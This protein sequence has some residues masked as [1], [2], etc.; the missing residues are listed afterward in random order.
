MNDFL[1]MKIWMKPDSCDFVSDDG[2]SGGLL[3][4]S[5]HSMPFPLTC[6]VTADR[7]TMDL[8][9]EWDKVPS[10]FSDMAVKFYTPENSF[11]YVQIKAS[12]AK[13]LQGHNVYGS[14]DIEL[15]AKHMLGL[16]RSAYPHFFA[17]LDLESTEVRRFD[18]TNSARFSVPQ[19]QQLQVIA[20]LKKLNNKKVLGYAGPFPE[21]VYFY[22]P[23]ANAKG[24]KL[25]EYIRRKC[26][27]KLAEL[28]HY[29]QK[30]DDAARK[31]RFI[32]QK[33]HYRLRQLADINL[34]KDLQAFAAGLFR[35]EVS[36]YPRWLAK[37]ENPNYNPKII[38]PS[39]VIH[40]DHSKQ[41]LDHKLTTLIKAQRTDPD[42][43]KKLWQ[44]AFKPITEAV[45]G[46]D[47]TMNTDDKI[48][49]A[50]KAKFST[51]DSKGRTRYTAANN[52]YKFYKSIKQEGYEHV[53]N[54]AHNKDVD[55]AYSSSSF[56]RYI[57]MFKK[58]GLTKNYLQNIE[59]EI[60]ATNVI[61]MIRFIDIDF[62]QQHPAGW[63][64]PVSE[65]AEGIYLSSDVKPALYAV[66]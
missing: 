49:T 16:L 17:K 63:R 42:I 48:H 46:G 10:S 50:L 57:G 7:T 20:N 62:S 36:V 45:D 8:N 38:L 9:C 59:S 35:W 43:F 25:S 39:G 53:F 2:L 37:Q 40:P 30:L 26:Y 12:P 47:M 33:E 1:D 55:G 19:N 34:D 18:L 24:S 32:D 41:F 27:L 60:Q 65:Y 61:P 6:R 44:K 15:C 58:I 64:E 22:D 23:Y 52:A 54:E 51:V 66:N 29:A 11:P 5:V 14:D 4:Q 21:T 13:L 3:Q 31:I 28:K 56:H